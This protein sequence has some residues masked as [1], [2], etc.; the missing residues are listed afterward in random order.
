MMGA[1]KTAVGKR[2]AQRLGLPFRDADEEIEAAAQMTIPEIFRPMARPSSATRNGA[3]SR[4]L[5]EQSGQIVLATGGGAFMNEDTRLT[6]AR[7]AVSVWLNAEFEVLM[8]RV[9]RK[10]NRPLLKTQDPEGTLRALI[11]KR[12]PIYGLADITV[13]SRD[14]AHD[15]VLEDVVAA[16]GRHLGKE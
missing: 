13:M 15:V 6:V 10:S 2:L 12:A 1:G 7:N 5:L 16:L 8:R 4:R 3:S 11:E 9:R 14:V